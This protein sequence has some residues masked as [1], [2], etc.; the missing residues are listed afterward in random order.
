[1]LQAET[2]S[3]SYGDAAVDQCA[4]QRI[5]LGAAWESSNGSEQ[6]SRAGTASVTISMAGT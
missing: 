3:E 2:G 4:G 1:M 6:G 5:R